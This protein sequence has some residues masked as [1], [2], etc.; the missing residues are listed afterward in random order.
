MNLLN[1][2]FLTCILISASSFSCTPPEGSS[3]S[4]AIP[5]DIGYAADFPG[6]ARRD[7]QFLEMLNA[8]TDAAPST[9]SKPSCATQ[10]KTSEVIAIVA[11]RTSYGSP[12]DHSF[13]TTD[14]H[15][16]TKLPRSLAPYAPE[17]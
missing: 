17:Q 13:V 14:T 9:D 4:K 16:Y 8:N 10:I 1:P 15:T 11:T 5:Y 12:R 7:L 3:S 6:S 2:A